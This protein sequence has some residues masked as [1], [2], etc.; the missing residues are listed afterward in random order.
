VACEGEGGTGG[1]IDPPD[2]RVVVRGTAEEVAIIRADGR[3]YVERRYK[4]TTKLG[5]WQ[6]EEIYLKIA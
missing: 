3:L 1:V 5:D 4:V 2:V 6:W